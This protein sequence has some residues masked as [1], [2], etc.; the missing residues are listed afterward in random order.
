[1]EHRLII[2]GIGPGAPDYI[3]PAAQRAIAQAEVLAGGRRALDSFA[4]P[5]QL[6]YAGGGDMAG[7]LQFLR[8]QV[9]T[10]KTRSEVRAY[11]ADIVKLHLSEIE[12][13]EQAEGRELEKMRADEWLL[14]LFEVMSE[15][16][17]YN[18]AWCI[19]GIH[20]RHA[21]VRKKAAQVLKGMVDEAIGG[22]WSAPYKIPVFV[23]MFRLM[24]Q[25]VI[26]EQSN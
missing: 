8:E 26:T 12:Y 6:T 11:A 20:Y 24:M 15:K 4:R 9:V 7:L 5:D 3:L 19:R 21:G 22:R 1:M 18:E 13:Y 25:D 17:K 2:V 16:R 23:D 10:E 14:R